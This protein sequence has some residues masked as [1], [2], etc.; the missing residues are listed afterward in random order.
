MPITD[1]TVPKEADRFYWIRLNNKLHNA[2]YNYC[3]NNCKT[4]S[5]KSELE[6]CFNY[7]YTSFMIE[8]KQVMHQAQDSDEDTFTTCLSKT[9]DPEDIDNILKCGDNTHAGKMLIIS[10]SIRNK[11]KELL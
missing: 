10:E 4:K 8:K 5:V 11:C 2:G 3:I 1:Y 7:C 6:G 9:D